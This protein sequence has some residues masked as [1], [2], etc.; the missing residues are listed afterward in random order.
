MKLHRSELKI[1]ESTSEWNPKHLDIVSI[2]FVSALLI[3]N[4]AAS[5]LFKLGPATFTAGILVFPISYIFG[6]VL[7]EVYGFNR[8][9]RVVYFGFLA[10]I[11]MALVLWIAIRLPPAPGWQFQNEFAAIHSLVPRVVLASVCGYLGG[12]LSN[13]FIMSRLKVL[14]NAR[15]LWM[16]TISSTIVGQFVDT[17]L[18][19]IVGFGGIFKTDLLIMTGL[20]GWLFKVT[21]EVIATPFTYIIVNKLKTLEGIEHFDK[22]ERPKLL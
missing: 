7:T 20:W 18:F 21:Y 22:K 13:S 5:K 2:I 6:D 10:N 9:R 4:I 19:A 8:A 1:A 11:F 17:S 16:R 14:T 12:E 3:S 15:F